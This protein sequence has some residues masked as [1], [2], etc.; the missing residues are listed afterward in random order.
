MR[1]TQ[2][3][4]IKHRLIPGTHVVL[5]TR[6]EKGVGQILLSTPVGNQWMMADSFVPVIDLKLIKTNSMLEVLGKKTIRRGFKFKVIQGG[7]V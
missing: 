3:Q 6:K 1:F 5:D 2:G 4:R 7:R